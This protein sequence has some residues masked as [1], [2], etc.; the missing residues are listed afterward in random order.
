V[1]TRLFTVG[2]VEVRT[3]VL[4]SMNRSMM[5]HRSKDYK[6]LHRGI[7]EKLRKAL[8]TDMHI[9]L[10]ATSSS[11]F[12]ESCVRCG[13]QSKMLGISNG[14]FGERWQKIGTANG[15]EVVKLQVPWGKAVR[16]KDLEGMVD[17]STEAVTLVSNESS[18]GVF[19][20]VEDLISAIREKGDPLVFID[21]VTSV[22]AIDLRL[23]RIDAD[24]LVF[25][26]QKALALPPGLAVICASDRLLEKAKSVENRGFYFDLL[27]LKK[28]ADKDYAMTTPPVSI[29]YGLDFQL[30]RMLKE[31]MAS[32]YERHQEMADMVREWAERRAGLFAEQGHRS[33]TITVVNNTEFNFDAIQNSLNGKGYEISGGYGKLKDETYRIGHM[34]DLTVPDIREFLAVMNEVMEE[35]A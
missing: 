2:P 3:E 35:L 7:V 18:T 22:G 10:A 32:R 29:M 20:P 31:G 33:N 27:E 9:I 30:D 24:A 12:L 8:E 19:N 1:N 28:Y 15:K 34:G 17:E 14:S 16:P 25:G 6:D 11:G 26:T 13:V 5:T 23:D 21:G 4:Q